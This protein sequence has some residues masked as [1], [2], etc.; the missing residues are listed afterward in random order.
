MDFL[1]RSIFLLVFLLFVVL[2]WIGSSIY[3]QSSEISINPNASSYTDQLDK[4]FQL[5]VL[6]EVVERTGK[7][8]PVSPQDFFNLVEGN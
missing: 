5:D 2:V 7:S 6:E 8:F 4:S 3:F 1:K